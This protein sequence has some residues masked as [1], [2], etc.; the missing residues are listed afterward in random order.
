MTACE[1]IGKTA[2][3]NNPTCYPPKR[4]FPRS[5]YGAPSAF[6][7]LKAEEGPKEGRRGAEGAPKGVAMGERDAEKGTIGIVRQNLLH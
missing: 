6:L 1:R 4:A 2:N 5:R 3:W 7:Q